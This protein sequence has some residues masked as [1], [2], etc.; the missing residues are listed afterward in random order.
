MVLILDD[1]HW[2]D[3][4]SLLLLEH[5]AEQLPELPC[6]V[7]GTYRDV[8]LEVARP[9]AR[10]LESLLRR[11]LAER[12]SLDRRHQEAVRELLAARAGQDRRRGWS[13]W[14][15]PRPRATR[16]SS[17]RCSGTWPRRGGCSTRPAGSAT[18][19]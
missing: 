5:L 11:K 15:S 18:G 1:L 13:G 10:T 6:L 7:V 3:E 8:E 12:V 14:S 2:A 16:S 19:W 9:L 17:R 4:P